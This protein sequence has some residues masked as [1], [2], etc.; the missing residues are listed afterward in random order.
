[1]FIGRGDDLM[2]GLMGAKATCPTCGTVLTFSD[3]G[4][5]ALDHNEHDSI[6]CH[7]CGS[8]YK[9]HLVP[10]KMTIT[11]KVKTI[12]INKPKR[13]K[14]K[15]EKPKV[16]KPKVEKPKVEKSISKPQKTITKTSE[17]Q[18]TQNDDSIIN[19]VL[20][21]LLYK[22]DRITGKKR[23]SV[24]KLISLLVFIL[25]FIIAY[26]MVAAEGF[27]VA[28]FASIIVGLVFAVPVFVIGYIIRYIIDKLSNKDSSNQNITS[29][30]SAPKEIQNDTP[31]ASVTRQD[32][33][34]DSA[35]NETKNED[36]NSDVDD[37][38]DNISDDTSSN[39][40]NDSDTNYMFDTPEEY[41]HKLEDCVINGQTDQI[42]DV[43][44]EAMERFPDRSDDFNDVLITGVKAVEKALN[45]GL[46]K[47]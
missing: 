29:T 37:K 21:I 45:E 35:I 2:D 1:M 3:A 8:V 7:N 27:F 46:F 22:N 5:L 47:K 24:T 13:E 31:V 10:N 12:P 11:S 25:F 18:K 9:V 19:K 39:A 36:L 16:E 44:D 30:T 40:S 38:V 15:V 4:G 43:Y 42:K 20:D 14:P 41:V 23:M 33:L 26:T 28:F 6:M 17:N 34:Y 32:S